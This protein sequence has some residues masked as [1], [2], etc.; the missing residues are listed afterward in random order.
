MKIGRAYIFL[1][2]EYLFICFVFVGEMCFVCICGIKFEVL[3]VP[4]I[5][6]TAS[7]FDL[8]DCNYLEEFFSQVLGIITTFIVLAGKI[9]IG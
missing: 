2:V 5:A 1:C 4:I 7:V 6:A 3:L 9:F 8:V